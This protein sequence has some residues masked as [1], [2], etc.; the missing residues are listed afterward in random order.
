M[1]QR[2]IDINVDN[3]SAVQLG[4]LTE[5]FCSIQGEGLCMGERQL[6]IRTAGCRAT[7]YW[8][9]SVSS[10]R[11]R[12]LCLIHG[13]QKRSLPNPLPADDAVREAL[14]LCSELGPIRTVSITGGATL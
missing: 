3:R 11:E 7:C 14:R 2:S 8:C 10:K 6:F 9:D 1:T 5:M 13:A 4:Y 12:S